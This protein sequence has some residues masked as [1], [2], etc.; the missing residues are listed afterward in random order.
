MADPTVGPLICGT[1]SYVGGT[2]VWTDYAYDDT[3]ASESELGAGKA[4]YD[5]NAVNAA[6]LIQLQFRNTDAGLLIRAV[7]QTLNDPSVPVLAVGFDTDGNGATGAP[8]FPGGAWDADPALGIEYLV[9]V[10]GSGAELRRFADGVWTSVAQFA[11]VVDTDATTIE[12]DRAEGALDPGR[13]TWRAF[14]G[15]GVATG[16]SS[17]LDGSGL[18]FDLAFVGNETPTRARGA[19]NAWQDR[20]Q[21]DILSGRYSSEHAAALVDF[22]KLADGVDDVADGTAPGNHTF[23]YRSELDLGGGIRPWP[24]TYRPE[25]WAE[26]GLP[27]T[28]SSPWKIYGGPYQPYGVYVPERLPT[29]APLIVFLH[30]TGSNHLAQRPR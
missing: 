29:P 4:V 16:G 25:L 3:G 17:F 18:I 5:D 1:A 13:A 15:V 2:F 12:S 23:L 22:G 30:G 21:A 8:G 6:D 14:A 27:T 9:V 19:G 10:T 20:N 7:L 11:S 26:L 24:D 28:P